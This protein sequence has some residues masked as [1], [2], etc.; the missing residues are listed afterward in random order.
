[1]ILK[2]FFTPAEPGGNFAFLIGMAAVEQ[3]L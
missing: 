1:M 3:E 2:W